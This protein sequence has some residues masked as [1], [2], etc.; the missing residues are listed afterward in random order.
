[1]VARRGAL[2]LFGGLIAGLALAVALALLIRARSPNFF[3]QIEPTDPVVYG[4]VAALLAL[5]ATLACL[6]PARRATRVDP[7]KALRAE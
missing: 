7:M 3:F 2:Q 1:M 5:V 6:V 4:G